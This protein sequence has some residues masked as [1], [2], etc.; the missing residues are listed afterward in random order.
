MNGWRV[1]HQPSDLPTVALADL[2]HHSFD[3][4]VK[5]ILHHE[6]D[7]R[8]Q[9]AMAPSSPSIED[10]P[11]CPVSEMVAL[12]GNVGISN[13]TNYCVTSDPAVVS[14][15]C[16]PYTR[17]LSTPIGSAQPPKAMKRGRHKR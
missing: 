7:T 6:L 5:A 10:S 12:P 17:L 13:A 11:A 2:L 8:A 16:N 9:E 4:T 3:P 1:I 14:N 15:I